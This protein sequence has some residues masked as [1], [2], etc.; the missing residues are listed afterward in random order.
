MKNR[1]HPFSMPGLSLLVLILL[2]LCLMTF[3]LLSLSSSSADEKL[4]QKTADRTT[5]YYA[6]SDSA[7]DLLEKIDTA[8]AEYLQQSC[9]TSNPENDW[10][11]SCHQLT[12]LI[13]GS[14]LEQDLFSFSVPVTD[15]QILLIG[16]K[17]SYPEEPSDKMYQITTWKIVNTAEWNPDT[18]Q[19][20]YQFDS[21]NMLF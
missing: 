17:L 8:L 12:E 20:L 16:L 18:S 5:V 7:N 1:K 21:E 11:S 19:N 15:D 6:A 4:S 13:E 3:S 9:M 10:I 2:S 14:T